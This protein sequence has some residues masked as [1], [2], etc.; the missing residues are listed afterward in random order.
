MNTIIEALSIPIILHAFIGML[1]AG[2]TLSLVGVIIIPLHLMTM[3]FT[4]MHVGLFGA[5]IAIAFN[6][7]PTLFAYFFV[8]TISLIMGLLTR[9][10]KEKASSIGAFFM[11][12]SLAG[13]FVILAATNVPA[14][15]V[16]DIFAGNILL[17]NNIDLFLTIFL[18]IVVIL[19][20]TI[21]YREIQLILLNPELAQVLGVPVKMM[22][23]LI[24]IILG[25]SVATALKLVGALLVDALLFLPA[26]AALRISKNFF[27]TLLLTSLFGFL[28]AFLG[29]LVALFF[30]LPIGASSALVSTLILALVYLFAY[31]TK[32]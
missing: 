15:E 17:M 28:T 6:L 13:A 24:F 21:T 22:M 30:S 27:S 2:S 4:L 7:S 23:N 26:V 18:G 20:F 11:T 19:F 12:G 16:F 5:A 1:F 14:M 3:R 32:N 10:K 25:F 8:V 31:I 9:D 29:F